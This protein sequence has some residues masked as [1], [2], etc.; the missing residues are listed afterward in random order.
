MFDYALGSLIFSI[1]S[2]E[3]KLLRPCGLAATQ[4]GHVVVVDLGNHCIKKF[5]YM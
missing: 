2:R 5:R 3:A 4:D 1:D